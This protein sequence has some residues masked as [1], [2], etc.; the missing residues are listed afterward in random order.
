MVKCYTKPSIKQMI[1]L[2]ALLQCTACSTVLDLSSGHTNHPPPYRSH[3][4]WADGNL[5]KRCTKMMQN[6]I[7]NFIT[8]Y[9]S[10]W[11]ALN[12]CC[13]RLFAKLI[14][15]FRRVHNSLDHTCKHLTN[16]CSLETQ[17]VVNLD[18]ILI[19]YCSGFIGLL[20]A[21]IFPLQL[22]S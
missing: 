5:T 17:Q 15:G 10:N 13:G 3:R 9:Y 7:V 4:S 16:I 11:Y 19:V 22:A 18:L 2:C 21:L 8:L 1:V 12:I 14:F 20:L 6:G